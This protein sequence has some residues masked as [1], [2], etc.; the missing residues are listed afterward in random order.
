MARF[1]SDK[2]DETNTLL[3]DLK[4][5]VQKLRKENRLFKEKTQK[6]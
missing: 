6:L 2:S 5:E 1:L 3:L 4:E